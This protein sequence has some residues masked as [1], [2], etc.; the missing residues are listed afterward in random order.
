LPAFAQDDMMEE[1]VCDSTTILLLYIAEHDYGFHSMMDVASFDKG[2]Y[3]P[4]FEEM[5]AMMDDG[6]MM[7]DADMEA[8]EEMMDE[9]MDEEEMMD[10]EMMSTLELPVI[11]GEDE[12]CTALRAELDTFFYDALF[13]MMMD[14]MDSDG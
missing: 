11:A 7:D 4:L 2:Q 3:A 6:E 13:G 5:M 10:D 1:H 14:D 12:A 8:T 9:S